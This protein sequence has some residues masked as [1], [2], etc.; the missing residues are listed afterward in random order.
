MQVIRVVALLG[1]LLALSECVPVEPMDSNQD[2][3]L[4]GYESVQGQEMYRFKYETSDGQFREEVGMLVNVGT[5]EQELMVMGQYGFKSKDGGTMVMVM[6]TSGKKGYR[7]RTVTRS[8]R[9]AD[10]RNKAF[11][12]LLMG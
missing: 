4:I 1:A 5:P 11:L 7:A 2:A 9:D 10:L 3:E 12:S 8:A 6:Y